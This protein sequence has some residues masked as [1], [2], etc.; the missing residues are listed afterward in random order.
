MIYFST[1]LDTRLIL[2]PPHLYLLW[3]GN[4]AGRA[5]PADPLYFF[6]MPEASILIIKTGFSIYYKAM[7]LEVTLLFLHLHSPQ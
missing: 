2:R 5:G 7:F 4:P 1:L 6:G 3:G